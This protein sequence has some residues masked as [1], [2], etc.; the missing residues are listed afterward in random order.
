MKKVLLRILC[1]FMSVVCFFVMNCVC[2]FSSSDEKA[3]NKIYPSENI[4]TL[5]GEENYSFLAEEG[6]IAENPSTVESVP[7]VSGSSVEISSVQ[8][9]DKHFVI[10]TLNAQLST[11]KTSD[12]IL[13]KYSDNWYSLSP[14]LSNLSASDSAYT[15]NE[16]GETVFIYYVET[17]LDGIR[18]VPD[19]SG[20]NFSNLEEEIT[21]ADNYLS[22]QMDN[23]GWDKKVEEQAKTAWD[24][25]S[26]KNKFSGWT[27]VDGEP[28][29]T[30]DNAATYT[31][32]RQIAAVYRE[33]KDE[34]Y[35]ESVERGLEFIFNLQYESGGFAQVYPRRG[36]YSDNVTFNDEAMI[37]VL[38]MLED[39]QNGA[40]P[41]DSDIISEEYKAK[42]ATSLEKAIDFILKSQIVSQGKLTA[43]CAQ[44]DPV[45]YEARGARAY[46]L[47]SI[48]GSESVAI[49][50]F[51]MSR[52]NQTDE[53]KNA[54]DCAIQWF[55]D[56]E[57]K[58]VRYYKNDPDEI[59]F[60]EDADSSLWYRFYEI[61][62]NLPIFCDRDGVAKHNI[63]EIGEER[64][65]G[66]SWS[67][68]W[69][70]KIISVYDDYGYYANKVQAYVS[71][72]NSKTSDGYKLV[73]KSAVDASNEIVLLKDDEN[74]SESSSESMSEESSSEESTSE[75]TSEESSSEES[76]GESSSEESSSE[77]SSSEST[78]EESSS[79]STNEES[80]SES[81]SEESSSEE[82]TSEESS[83]EESSS[84]ESSS[85]ETS[86]EESSSEESSSESTSEESSSEESSSDSTSE[87]STSEE[88]S[89]EESSSESTSEE[90]TSEESSSES[91]TSIE[92]TSTEFLPEDDKVFLLGDADGDGILTINDASLILQ[93]VLNNDNIIYIKNNNLKRI[94][95][96]DKEEITALDSAMVLKKVLDSLWKF[97]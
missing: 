81:T 21:V 83:S 74:L 4:K 41:F 79:E 92:P 13:K 55:K 16:K 52:K 18:I 14:S 28:I 96:A 76:S 5:L 32:M 48:S 49:V 72:N 11:V 25:V 80:T 29:G 68:Q 91:E 57:V 44:H 31:Q 53:I 56:S 50:K 10:V 37:S 30:I 46:E 97:D 47:P 73:K 60:V 71:K 39:M 27:S 3:Q 20:S 69:P 95:I 42:I 85:E 70:A 35:K 34:K 87:E 36:N 78:S 7:N 17:E 9:F 58:G 15:I 40:Y 94:K 59:Y 89:S 2:V 1:T 86:S 66:Y 33:V 51:L 61:G 26:A 45:S 63:A 64:R 90:S 62:T 77:E 24:G 93:Y 43:W 65:N 88:S 84:E 22:W 6:V 23:G 38:I 8:T 67:G 12:I 75:S 19:R 82:S 54:V